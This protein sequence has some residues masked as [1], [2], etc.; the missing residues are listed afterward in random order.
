MDKSVYTDEVV[1]TIQYGIDNQTEDL[2]YG[3]FKKSE[4]STEK[5]I[6]IKASTYQNEADCFCCLVIEEETNNQKV[7]ILERVNKSFERYFFQ[8]CLFVGNKLQNRAM[9]MQNVNII[10]AN[11][12]QCKNTIYNYKDH[13]QLMKNQFKMK[14][15]CQQKS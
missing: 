4:D 12:C 3:I 10:K 7:K 11:I 8:F 1:N 14:I 5:R 9:N 13:I 6:S 15:I 2:F